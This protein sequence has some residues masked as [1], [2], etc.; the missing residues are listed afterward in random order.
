MPSVGMKSPPSLATSPATAVSVSQQRGRCSVD[1]FR[2]MAVVA[3]GEAR[4][5]RH[6]FAS[7]REQIDRVEVRE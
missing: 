3:R 4:D 2:A 1:T 6:P 5:H 7:G